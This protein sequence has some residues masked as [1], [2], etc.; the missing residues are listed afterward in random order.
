VNGG[1][2][3]LS[4]PSFL[5]SPHHHLDHPSVIPDPE[6]EIIHP[7]ISY[8][9]HQFSHPFECRSFEVPE[10]GL[11]TI[12]SSSEVSSQTSSQIRSL[13]DSRRRSLDIRKDLAPLLLRTYSH[14]SMSDIL[15]PKFKAKA[16]KNS[17]FLLIF[18]SISYSQLFFFYF[19]RICASCL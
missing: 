17:E 13:Y 15:A 1:V 18:L 8:S 3:G 4:R 11:Q 16:P 2:K 6:S 5:L 7:R 19:S 12:E 9:S 14:D 10:E